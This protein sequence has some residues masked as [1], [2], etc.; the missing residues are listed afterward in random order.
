MF[1]KHR[2]TKRRADLCRSRSLAGSRSCGAT[3]IDGNVCRRGDALCDDGPEPK[4]SNDADDADDE[5]E[6]DDE[7]EDDERRDDDC[8]DDDE[9]E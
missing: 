9:A 5:V 2:S 6:E 3:T 1:A 7:D 4:D 8:D